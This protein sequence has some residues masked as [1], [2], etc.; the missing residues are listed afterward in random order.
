MTALNRA[1]SAAARSPVPGASS[2]WSV[3]RRATSLG[4]AALGTALVAVLAS[5][6]LVANAQSLRG[7]SAGHSRGSDHAV[8][9]QTD[10]TAGNEIIAYDRSDS[11]TLTEAGAYQTGGLGGQLTGSVV[12]H[13]ASQGSLALDRAAGLLVAVNAGS[14]TI[15]VFGV[16]GDEL[17]LQQVTGSGGTFPV[18]VAIHG[19]LAYVLNA[20]DGGAVQ[21]YRIMPGGLEQL[22]GSNRA[23]GLNQA[24]TPQFT[25][26]PGQVAFSPD[27]RQLIVTTKANGNDIDVFNVAQGGDL[28]GSLVVNSEP[29]TVP[30][31]I[32]FDPA[33]NLVIAEAGTNALATFALNPSGAV[34]PIATAATGQAATC[35]VTPVRGLLFADNAGSASVSTFASGPAGSLTGLGSPVSTDAG[36]VDSAASPSGRFLYVQT[37]AAGIVDEFAV[38]AAG[39][40]TEI[41][42]VTVPG[43]VGGE[44]IVVG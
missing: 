12:D 27:G 34:T 20:E 5:P 44:G 31:A 19:D 16:R 10:N 33:G 42:K 3:R 17:R 2:R 35:W 28:S 15:S 13:L 25:N 36:T 21:G 41:G 11:G 38:T 9:V 40:L 23:L 18:S 1:A 26:T 24:A 8:F 39:A 43:A 6:A 4:T 14:N 37:G 32:A 29:G 30:F 7:H 22:P